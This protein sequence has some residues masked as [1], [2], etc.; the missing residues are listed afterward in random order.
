MAA[1]LIDGKIIA[2]QIH[3]ETLL[4][5]Q[6]LHARGIQPCILF[7]RIGNDP[8]SMAYVGMKD[9][10]AKELGITAQTHVFPEGT[11]ENELLEFIHT[12]NCNPSIHGILVQAPIPNIP[13][14]VVFSAINPAKDVDG[15]HP[16]NFG[17]LLLGDPSGFKPCTPAGVQELLLRSHLPT[18]GKHVVILGRG[19]IVGKPLA[20][21]LCQKGL[22]A[23][24]TVTLAHSRTKNLPNLCLQADILIAAMGQAEFVKKDF[25]KPGAV[26]IDVGVNRINDVSQPKGFR[27]VGDIDFQAVCEVASYVTPNPGGVGPMTIAML[28]SNTVIAAKN[29]LL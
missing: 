14:E 13:Q 27:L 18:Q 11:Q 23:D 3:A 20:A 21:L 6:S 17:K 15:F 25:I 24:A 5:V 8:A 9:R 22:G 28:L 29:Q 10:K 26:V 4:K 16:I 7:I 2:Q 12:A 1:Q 19:N